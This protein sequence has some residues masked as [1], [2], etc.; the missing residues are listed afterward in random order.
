ML[1]AKLR[2]KSIGGFTI[3][4]LLI[5]MTVF[6]LILT[7]A[8]FGMVQVGRA[9]YKG[10]IVSRTQ[11]TA[12]SILDDIS[13]TIQL[14]GGDIV[15]DGD[16]GDDGDV[17]E[18][19]TRTLCIGSVRYSVLMN[20]QL[21]ESAPGS[22]DFNSGNL[23][24]K[25]VFWKDEI[26]GCGGE[27]SSI[28]QNELIAGI[29]DEGTELLGAN[30]RVTDFQVTNQENSSL[31]TITLSIAYGDQDLLDVVDDDDGNSRTICAPG[32]AGTQFCAISEL[33]TTVMRRLESE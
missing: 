16:D 15:F 17:G 3:I 21:T 4:E 10:V 29:N 33:S 19:R 13:R 14:S 22:D 12:R 9:Y 8:V 31:Y 26:N 30:M 20:A 1:E 27:N 24:A 2:K 32:V 18:I 6:S 28:S 5:A 7:A 23:Q 11:H 25:N